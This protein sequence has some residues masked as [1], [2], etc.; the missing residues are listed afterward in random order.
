LEVGTAQRPINILELTTD[1]I[2]L[3]SRLIDF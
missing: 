2:D 1:R 3:E